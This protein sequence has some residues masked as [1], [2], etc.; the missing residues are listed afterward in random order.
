[1][2]QGVN[3]EQSGL[4]AHRRDEKL[5]G[6]LLLEGGALTHFKVVP[7][8]SWSRKKDHLVA[9]FDPAPGNCQFGSSQ[10]LTGLTVFPQ[11]LR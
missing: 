2:N 3:T 8:R 10:S 1:M 7:E 6:N 4:G 5:E 9:R 11:V